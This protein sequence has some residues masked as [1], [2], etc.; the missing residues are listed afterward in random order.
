MD[1]LCHRLGAGRCDPQTS[2]AQIQKVIDS[3]ANMVALRARWPVVWAKAQLLLNLTGVEDYC[4][5][6]FGGP[7]DPIARWQDSNCTDV[8]R[9]DPFP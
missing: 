3:A 9:G 7:A 2:G 5:K 8:P 1:Q 6:P 4:R